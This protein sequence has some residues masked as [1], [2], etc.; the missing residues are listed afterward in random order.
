MRALKTSVGGVRGVVGETL[1]PELIVNFSQAFGTLVGPAEVLIS[2]DTRPSGLMVASCV[3]AGLL[4]TGCRVVDL[5]VCPT[6]ALQLAVRRSGAAGG[7]AVTAGHNDVTWNAL[8]FI[9]DDGMF[10]NWR[11]GE[12]LLNCYHQ[13]EFRKV[14]WSGLQPVRTGGEEVAEAHLEA[15]LEQLDCATIRAARLKVAVDCCN[16]ACS[17][18]APRF[19]ERLG[20]RVV[21][22]NTEP[23]QPFP[24]EPAPSPTNLGQLRALVDA[25][26]ADLGFAHDT[27]GDRLGLVTER[28]VA[29]GEEHTLC[30]ATQMIL[31]RGDPGPV[32]T[33]VSTTMALDD[34]AAAHGRVVVRTKVGEAYVA[35]AAQVNEAAV[36]GEGS[37]GVMFPRLNY[38]H[39]SIAA[40]GHILEFRA[41]CDRPTGELAA[42]VPA[43]RMVKLQTACPSQRAFAVLS[44]LRA[45]LDREGADG[46]LDYEDGVKITGDGFWVHVRASATEPIIRVISESRD[47]GVAEE[48]AQRLMLRVRR[49][50]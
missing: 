10:F 14:P 4:G 2:R 13:R 27:D 34:V 38:T 50:I 9:R 42:A 25:T 19:L 8:K 5:G 22:I 47:P 45:D 24:H 11:Q 28:G 33:N 32:V 48:R 49:A 3:T 36:G 12:E 46:E 7:I 18:W 20:C 29:P 39:D 15:I 41:R 37:G 1:E 44:E 21:A 30:L 16:G 31:G 26:G 40:M 23:D 43:Y 6:A 17:A 35:E